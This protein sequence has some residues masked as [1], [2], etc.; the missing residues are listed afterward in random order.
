M[1][2]PRPRL[3]LSLLALAGSL[4]AGVVLAQEKAAGPAA[5]PEDVKSIDATL[6]TLYDVISG[7]AGQKRDWDRFR[8]LFVPGARLIPV[9]PKRDGSKGVNARVLDPEAFVKLATANVEKDGF[10]EKEI[11]RKTE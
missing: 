4:L 7:P 5:K 10:F 8:S 6:A 2:A 3:A 9:V 1:N 11:A